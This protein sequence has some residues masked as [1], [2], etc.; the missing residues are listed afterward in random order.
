[1]RFSNFQRFIGIDWAGARDPR[2]GLAVAQCSLDRGAPQIVLNEGASGWRR[3][4]VLDWLLQITNRGERLVAGFD[5]AFAY[6]Y[7]DAGDY[8]PG[9][10]GS[11]ESLEALWA[12]VDEI[13]R[14]ADDFY[15]GP[16]YLNQDAPFADYLLYQNYRG[17]QYS[18][19]LRITDSLCAERAGNPASPFKCV[20]PE[21]VGIGSVAG[22]RLLHE[23]NSNLNKDFSIWPFQRGSKG[24][25]VIVEI[26][27][28][29]FYIMAGADPRAW[30]NRDNVNRALAWYDS[31]ALPADLTLETEDQVD[32][33]VSAAAIRHLAT[34]RDTWNPPGLSDCARNYEGWILGV[35]LTPNKKF[36]RR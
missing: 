35:G 3:R 19:R 20:G 28:R 8:F 34:N 10:D 13:C 22:M 1:M 26:F 36:N 30:R 7:C 12:T 16:F 2:R 25:S 17:N 18:P 23:V 21:S 24:Q 4:E 15:G 27:P 9:D 32:A 31:E 14:E 29:F 33:M 11:P 5:F 6:P